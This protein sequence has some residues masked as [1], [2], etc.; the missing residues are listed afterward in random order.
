MDYFYNL[1]WTKREKC[2]ENPLFKKVTVQLRKTQQV[3]YLSP[4]DAL[5]EDIKKPH[6]LKKV[7][8]RVKNDNSW[9]LFLRS[10]ETYQFRHHVFYKKNRDA[11]D[12]LMVQIRQPIKLRHIRQYIRKRHHKRH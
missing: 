5:M 9:W 11:R 12:A 4:R 3:K 8:T 2:I 1:F 6:K 10:I 7:E